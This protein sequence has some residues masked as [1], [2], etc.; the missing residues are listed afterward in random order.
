MKQFANEKLQNLYLALIAL[1]GEDRVGWQE[2]G[3]EEEEM[4]SLSIPLTNNYIGKEEKTTKIILWLDKK[5]FV[6]YGE[7]LELEQINKNYSAW[8]FE[9]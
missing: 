8:A 4:I 6:C 5:Q 9:N 1:C 2:I 7:P 3:N